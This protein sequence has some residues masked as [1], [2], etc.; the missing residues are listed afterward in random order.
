MR[1]LWVE[2]AGRS[3]ALSG[4]RSCCRFAAGRS[5]LESSSDNALASGVEDGFAVLLGKR[6][7]VGVGQNVEHNLGRPANRVPSG[8]TTKG[9]LMR[10][11]CS[12]I[13]SSSSS[14]LRDGSPRPS[15]AKG[16]PFSRI[17]WRTVSPAAAIIASS[18]ARE[19][20]FFRYSTTVGSMPAL[21]IMASVLREVPQAGLW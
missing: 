13:A 15:S 5:W 12:S 20:G 18:S 17:A 6:T 3:L 1:G 9:R 4:S 2:K 8:A 10:I 16:V 14:S 11:G 19:G 7:L 21:R